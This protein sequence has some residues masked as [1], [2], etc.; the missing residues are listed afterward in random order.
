MN[1][2]A[3]SER[4]RPLNDTKHI[5]TMPFLQILK[6]LRLNILCIKLLRPDGNGYSWESVEDMLLQPEVSSSPSPQRTVH[7]GHAFGLLSVTGMKVLTNLT[8]ES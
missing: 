3:A 1:V 4:Q 8:L 2:C 7:I 5:I 6:C